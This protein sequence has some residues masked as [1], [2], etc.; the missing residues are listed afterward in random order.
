MRAGI[1]PL[2]E[3]CDVESK[4]VV[5]DVAIARHLSEEIEGSTVAGNDV[6]CTG[7]GRRITYG[8]WKSR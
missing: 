5:L 3:P 4:E 2:D 7:N 8:R 1:Q 6:Q